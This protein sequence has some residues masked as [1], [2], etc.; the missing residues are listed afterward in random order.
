M[1]G[2]FLSFVRSGCASFIKLRN[3]LMS[4]FPSVFL[5]TGM[6][7]VIISYFWIVGLPVARI[8]SSRSVV[9]LAVPT[10]F[11]LFCTASIIVNTVFGV[12]TIQ[13]LAI[14]ICCLVLSATFGFRKESF[15][16]NEGLKKSLV[17]ISFC[18]LMS[19]VVSLSIYMK[20]E[21]GKYIFSS[22]I[23]DHI[24]I[25]IIDSIK[26]DGLPI[27]N[28]FM[29]SSP[30][31]DVINYYYLWYLSAANIATI[32]RVSGWSSDIAMT[33]VTA[34][35]SLMVVAALIKETTSGGW[36]P[37]TIGMLGVIGSGVLVYVDRMT[38][39]GVWKNMSHEH[40]MESWIIQA[41]WVPQHMASAAF[42]CV[43]CFFLPS[44]KDNFDWKKWTAFTSLIVAGF[45]CSTWVG[46]I[47]FAIICIPMVMIDVYKNRD[48]LD[49]FFFK[50]V[51]LCISSVI[52]S[53]PLIVNQIGVAG[54][55]KI[56]PVGIHSYAAS[57]SGNIGSNI[58]AFLLM[59]I[60]LYLPVV[61]LSFAT[62]VCGWKKAVKDVAVIKLFLIVLFSV[63]T[64]LFVKSQIANNDLGWRAI[65]PAT[66]VAPVLLAVMVERI[67][68]EYVTCIVGLVIA[69]SLFS[70]FDFSQKN[71][72]GVNGYQPQTDLNTYLEV[73]RDTSPKDRLFVNSRKYQGGEILDGN[74][75]PPIVM[76]R[77]LCFD[78]VTFAL[79][80]GNAWGDKLW[81]MWEA[82][83]RIYNGSAS[84]TD[85]A[86]MGEMRCN[87][88][89]VVKGDG[90]WHNFPYS[91]Y[92]WKEDKSGEDYRI[93]TR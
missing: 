67:K 42:V 14:A 46:G 84:A 19:L 91:Q 59:F 54:D 34:T 25:A 61:A 21:D 4:F 18:L 89:V 3:Y 6:A 37:F 81:K 20:M 58:S 80:F 48:N 64:S 1:V 12:G 50:W 35:S 10:G 31:S 39:G 62:A 44:I 79:A 52:I 69:F 92:G 82:S 83:V 8:I 29:L 13:S 75:I 24:K 90:I 45:G 78:N 26:R 23:F 15:K 73:S 63:L 74:I 28:P 27:K 57:K 77:N 47:T 51:L 56:S 22:P 40:S 72:K 38:M 43:S 88:F 66:L 17:V 65:I 68:R 2:V 70:T 71:I 7:L 86:L 30:T 41:S 85:M 16:I 53:T 33:F 93:Y 76:N 49:T 60:P 55:S 32:F 5:V 87:K 36:K 9:Y 11:A